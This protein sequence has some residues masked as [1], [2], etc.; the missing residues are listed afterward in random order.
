ML[1]QTANRV[2]S[3]AIFQYRDLRSQ[4]ARIVPSRDT[5]G[6][7]ALQVDTQARLCQPQ[8]RISSQS[9]EQIFRNGTKDS[10]AIIKT[11]GASPDKTSE[12][13]GC[14]GGSLPAIQEQTLQGTCNSI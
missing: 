1:N 10:L 2:I 7:I 9:D 8:P 4:G 14:Y 3:C 5:I 6:V 12:L 13:F 11:L